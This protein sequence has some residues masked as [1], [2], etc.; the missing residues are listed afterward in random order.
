MSL[1]WSL[2]YLVITFEPMHLHPERKMELYLQFLLTEKVV[3][4]LVSYFDFDSITFLKDKVF[5]SI[6][7]EQYLSMKE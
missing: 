5:A 4:N 1:E 2:G 3:Q 7:E 6:I